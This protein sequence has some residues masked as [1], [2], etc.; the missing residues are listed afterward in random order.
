MTIFY[1]ILF[2]GQLAGTAAS[3]GT[4]RVLSERR[5]ANLN[6]RPA[7]SNNNRHESN[8]AWLKMVGLQADTSPVY[9]NRGGAPR[10]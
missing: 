5:T 3:R 6:L 9:V 4:R 10:A 1:M 7:S 8:R 2:Y